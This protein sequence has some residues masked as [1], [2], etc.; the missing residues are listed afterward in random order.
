M[1]GLFDDNMIAQRS[2]SW[3]VQGPTSQHTIILY[4]ASDGRGKGGGGA[5]VAD[6]V[7]I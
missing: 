1:Q 7:L 4:D 2:I 6:N 3:K 5:G